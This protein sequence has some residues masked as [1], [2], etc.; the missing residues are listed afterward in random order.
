MNGAILSGEWFYKRGMFLFLEPY[1][2]WGRN[3]V[4]QTGFLIEKPTFF[5]LKMFAETPRFQGLFRIKMNSEYPLKV[6]KRAKI[7]SF[8]LSLMLQKNKKK[9]F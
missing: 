3:A 7:D 5:W 1:H 2:R 8:K 6:P 9:D 4:F